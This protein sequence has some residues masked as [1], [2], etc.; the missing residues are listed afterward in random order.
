M[1]HGLGTFGW[2]DAWQALLPEGRPE[3]RPARVLAVHYGGSF[4]HDA[5]NGRVLANPT[6]TLA[7]KMRRDQTAKLAVG[8]WVLVEEASPGKV[9]VH[10]VLARRSRLI[11]RAAGESDRPQLLCANIDRAFIVTSA[12]GDWNLERIDR[13]LRVTREGNIDATLVVTK[14]DLLLGE[15]NI[16]G[17]ARERFA[18]LAVIVTSAVD[19]RGLDELDAQLTAKCTY[20]LLGSSGVGKSTLVN[21]W[22]SAA[23]TPLQA[24][25]EV[26][27][28]DGKG[29]HTTTHRE[30][31][32]TQAGALVIDTP[33]MREVGVVGDEQ[34]ATRHARSRKR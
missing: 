3:L 9:S 13:Y 30:L 29:R 23:G 8:D 20:A 1:Q 22:L 6:G 27:E 18:D 31:F 4:V 5:I 7:G 11:R 2:D 21:R 10:E 26:R 28:S 25:G 14:G 15:R 32:R 17:E 33:G 19:G 12:D 16:I 34:T 24:V